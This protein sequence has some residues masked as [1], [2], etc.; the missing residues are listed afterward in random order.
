[1]QCSRAGATRSRRSLPRATSSWKSP[2]KC[3]PDRTRNTG[4]ARGALR[5]NARPDRRGAANDRSGRPAWTGRH[6]LNGAYE[7]ADISASTVMELRQRTGL[8][9]MECK[10]ALTE[11]DGDLAKAEEPVSYTH[12][13]AHETP[14]QLVCR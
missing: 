2:T 10:K 7:M 12:L 3:R 6:R 14:E 5:R 11:A 9:M 1:M 13:R 4:R 8:G